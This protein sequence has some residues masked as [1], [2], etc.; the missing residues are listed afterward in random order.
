MGVQLT[1]IH[2]ICKDCGKDKPEAAFPMVANRRGGK[3]YRYRRTQCATCG[4]R[5]KRTLGLRVWKDRLKRYRNR[6]SRRA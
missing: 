2:M 4:E 3:V 5:R 6:S 1:P